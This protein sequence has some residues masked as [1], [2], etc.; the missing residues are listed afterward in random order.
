MPSSG[1]DLLATPLSFDL[2]Q[3]YPNPFNPT[4]TITFSLP[5]EQAVE[6]V[7]SIPK[8]RRYEIWL[9]E[10]TLQDNHRYLGWQGQPRFIRSQ[11][12]VFLPPHWREQGPNPQ[13]AFDEMKQYL[14]LTGAGIS[15]ESGIKTFRDSGGLWENH[16]V[17]DVA[18][19]KGFSANPELVWDFYK[20]RY[21]QSLTVEPNPAHYALA[22]MEK[23]LGK[24][25]NLI[26]Q[27]VD[28][29]H[30]R[31]GNTR[32]WEMHGRLNSCLCTGCRSRFSMTD[33]T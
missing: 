18:S 2:A 15:A 9:V 31:A 24:H 12:H 17:E 28:G 25:F 13:D 23:L 29:L 32:C 14:V 5:R 4:T 3:N 1:E 20:Q 27:N 33:M 8:D 7:I 10:I 16:K 21:Q 26:T 6:L 19:P 30:Q 11:W 22:E